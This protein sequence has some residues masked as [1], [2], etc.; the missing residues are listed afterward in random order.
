MQLNCGMP[1]Q[2]QLL[3]LSWVRLVLELSVTLTLRLVREAAGK[4]GVFRGER[5][6]GVMREIS[7][8]EAGCFILSQ[9]WVWLDS[10]LHHLFRKMK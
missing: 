8:I 9:M 7:Y 1:F 5:R 4:D 10:E 6:R 3:V 2:L